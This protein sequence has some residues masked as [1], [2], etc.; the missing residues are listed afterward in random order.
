MKAYGAGAYPGTAPIGG[1]PGYGHYYKRADANALVTD[2]YGLSN[3]L[4]KLAAGSLV[5]LDNDFDLKYSNIAM[6]RQIIIASDRGLNGS[7][8]ALLKDY[9]RSGILFDVSEGAKFSGFRLEGIER[10]ATVAEVNSGNRRAINASSK[11]R[12]EVENCEVSYFGYMGL[13]FVTASIARPADGSL[14]DRNHVHHCDIHHIQRHGFGYGVAVEWSNVLIEANKISHC[15]HL[16]MGQAS[17]ASQPTH[18]EALY[19]IF[20]PALYYITDY[21]AWCNSQVDCHGDADPNPVGSY[22]G[23]LLIVRY[24]TFLDNAVPEEGADRHHNVNIRGTPSEWC[25][26]DHNWIQYAGCSDT[27]GTQSCVGQAGVSTY[28][29]MTV[30]DNYYGYDEPPDGEP[31]EP[32]PPA[33]IS[34]GIGLLAGFVLAGLAQRYRS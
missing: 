23:G 16:I 20:G 19:N 12:V 33:G 10:Y 31:V 15:R 6:P 2:A 30:K 1:G 18:Y 29:R 7:P 34:A 24:N 17:N 11:K 25:Y 27:S 13:H 32:K 8:G 28:K 9:T 3:E 5:W 26:V 21:G 14:G 4:S 22:A